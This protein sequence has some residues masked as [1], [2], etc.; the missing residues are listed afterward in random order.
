MKCIFKLLFIVII[1]SVFPYIF[2]KK[3]KKKE[4]NPNDLRPTSISKELFCDACQAIIQEA[5]KRLRG[6]KKESDVLNYLTKVC[7]PERYN[8]YHFP[9]PQM[10]EG[11]EAFYGAY[12]DE[13]E[14]VLINRDDDAN[15]VKQFCYEETRV[16]NG[17]DFKNLNMFDDT[18]TVDGEPM[19]MDEFNK[20][21]K[22]DL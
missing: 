15:L 12:G 3:K 20:K 5:I 17:V 1:F 19:K 10:R 11:C 2:S 9:P 8:I 4:K 13:V 7:D 14:K 6:L 16:C 22:E 21:N 18:I